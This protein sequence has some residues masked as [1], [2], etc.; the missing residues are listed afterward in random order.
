MSLLSY[1]LV[2][3]IAKSVVWIHILHL[4]IPWLFHSKTERL[5]KEHKEW[6]VGSNL[7]A[8]EGTYQQ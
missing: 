8:G 4:L 1:L 6:K 2:D 5:A 3:Y 7:N